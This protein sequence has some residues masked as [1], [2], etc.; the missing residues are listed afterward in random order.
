MSRSGPRAA[1]PRCAASFAVAL[2]CASL[3]A[4]A[5][6]ARAHQRLTRLFDE[7]DGLAV[8]EI[9][10]LAQDSR[11]F[12]WIGGSGGVV[13]YDGREFRPWAP[14]RLRHVVRALW[15]DQRGDVLVAA[16]NEPLW[17]VRGSSVDTLAGPDGRAMFDW[18]DA[19][20]APD[21]TVGVV[22]SDHLELRDRAGRWRR[23][24]LAAFDSSAFVR[25]LPWTNDTLLV[26]TAHALY[27]V[28]GGAPRRIASAGWVW[29]ARPWRDG[30]MIALTR[31]GELWRLAGTTS[32]LLLRG[33]RGAG[34]AVRQGRIWAAMGPVVL[35]LTPGSPPDTIAPSSWCP[36]GQTP[37]VDHEDN[38]WLGCFGGIV[39][40]PEP[41]TRIWGPPEGLPA[42]PHAFGVARSGEDV[43]V[44]TWFGACDVHP[45]DPR[46]NATPV[47]R[48]SGG[49]YTD[50]QGRL[51]WADVDRGFRV[52]EHGRERFF[53]RAGLHRVAASFPRRD[54]TTWLATDD[55]PF[56]V[57]S[58]EGAPTPCAT[59]P[60]PAWG[61]TWTDAWI[62]GVV[63]D[64]HG[65][66]WLACGSEVACADADSVARGRPVAWR[67]SRLEGAEYI[68]ALRLLN[69][70]DLW[71]ATSVGGVWRGHEDRWTVE[72]TNRELPSLR[73][74][75]LAPAR[76]G[77]WW[78]L[79]DGWIGRVVP[80]PVAEGGGWRVT[81]S[82]SA[83]QGLPSL[84][85]GGLLED[86]DGRLWIA[87]LLGLVEL[88][89]SARHTPRA[90]PTVELVEARVGGRAIP[91]GE[92]LRLPFRRNDLSLRFTALSFRDPSHLRFQAR[93]LPGGS[94]ME[95][96]E[97]VFNAVDVS[98]GRHALEVRASL[99]GM[100]WSPSPAR[101][102]F[103]VSRPWYLEPWALAVFVL[104][105]AVLVFAAHR[106]RV[107]MLLRLERQR[108]RIAMDLHD[109]MGSGLGSIGILAG[110]AAE[111]PL[112]DGARRRLAGEIAS[113]S[114]DLGSTLSEIVRSLRDGP[115]TLDRWATQLVERAQRLVPGPQP[116]LRLVFP[117][118]VPGT[119]LAPEV[120]RELMLSA[121]E[122][123]HNAVRHAHATVVTLGLE[124]DGGGW[125]LWVEDDGCGLPPDAFTRSGSFGLGNMRHRLDSVHGSVEWRPREGGGTHVEMRFEPGRNGN[126]GGGL[127]RMF[128][129]GSGNG[130]NGKMR[131]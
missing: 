66:L 80:R 12:L 112:E 20:L 70:G 40:M 109:E 79:A 25:L 1:P 24:P 72:P 121:V 19:A 33:D 89:A 71:A 118:A 8:A 110:M 97:P 75:D 117:S 54:G 108:L 124:P 93:L 22:T 35:G 16:A 101:L 36:T 41:E 69:D 96:R 62:T 48:I 47:G 126:G 87:S 84:Q 99:D 64:T 11:G 78:L 17:Q 14:E 61:R 26:S 46:R 90:L 10:Q 42:P 50:A 111:A 113:L 115:D 49:C 44:M 76:D 55:G 3:L 2:A 5:G 37:Y 92:P 32:E 122:A 120:R 98:S 57:R 31:T 123:L 53:A 68:G 125:R 56:L 106:L 81:E 39:Q 7:R 86:P 59:T 27:A 83:W 94:W 60:P 38:L 65:R 18:K 85:A 30:G 73:V 116:E 77:G 15:T 45:A 74:Y 131:A 82:L 91:L 105:A 6:E 21:G 102:D 51:W 119:G 129:R 43:R 103:A 23:V 130:S 9:F 34:L 104:G 29:A 100:H 127:R 28:A 13:R 52:R 88:P 67:V 95:T 114:S 58:G 63:E 107:A 128:V 4:L